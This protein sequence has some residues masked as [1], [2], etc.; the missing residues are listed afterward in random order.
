MTTRGKA[1]KQPAEAATA[2]SKPKTG[3]M[4]G[5]NSSA[6]FYCGCAVV[7]RSTCRDNAQF[8]RRVSDSRG[9]GSSTAAAPPAAAAA[10]P[11]ASAPEASSRSRRSAGR[12]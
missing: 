9:G 1:V 7:L 8:R 4:P 10:V 6:G 12:P 5:A 3:K 2:T 11:A